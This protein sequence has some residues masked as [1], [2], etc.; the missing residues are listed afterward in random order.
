MRGGEPRQLPWPAATAGLD[1]PA[2]L[3]HLAAGALRTGRPLAIWREP[4]AHAP[5]LRLLHKYPFSSALKRMAC[6][7]AL[8]HEGT[9]APLRVVAKGAAD[10]GAG[11]GDDDGVACGHGDYS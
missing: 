8:E 3:R 6:V 1:A 7:V 4:G 9:G 10:R 11:S 5:R 2:R